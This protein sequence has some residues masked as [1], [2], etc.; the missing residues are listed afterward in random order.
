MHYLAELAV[1]IVTIYGGIGAGFVEKLMGEAEPNKKLM[2]TG[3]GAF[4]VATILKMPNVGAGMMG[5]AIYKAMESTG[6]LAEDMDLQEY[7]YANPIEALPMVLNDNGEDMMFQEDDMFLQEDYG[8]GYY[9]Y[10]QGF[11]M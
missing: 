7:G 4:A 5:V 1:S 2:V 9:Q 6:M 3:A 8:V 10:G 11:G